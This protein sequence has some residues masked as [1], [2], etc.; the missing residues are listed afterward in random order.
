MDDLYTV[1]RP[2][3][4][5]ST[6]NAYNPSVIL[7]GGGPAWVVYLTDE[8]FDEP[9]DPSSTPVP[10]R[11]ATVKLRRSGATYEEWEG[12][13]EVVFAES[14]R[15]Y[16]PGREVCWSGQYAGAVSSVRA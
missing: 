2:S 10:E 12:E 13:P 8:D 9:P 11:R 14:R 5:G 6:F 16:N 7:V 4:T 1:Y 3:Q 15:C